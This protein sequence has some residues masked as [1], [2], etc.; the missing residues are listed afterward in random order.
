MTEG[1]ARATIVRYWW[2]RAQASLQAA[3][4]ELAAGAY[5][6]AINRAWPLQSDRHPYDK[7]GTWGLTVKVIDIFGSDT[8]QTFVV[9]VQ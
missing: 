3:R 9:Q 7:A 1:E 8:S 5:A 2:D 6:F 4:R